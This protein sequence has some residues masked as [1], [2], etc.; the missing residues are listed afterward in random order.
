MRNGKSLREYL[1]AETGLKAVKPDGVPSL[2]AIAQ[3]DTLE[4]F[5]LITA[6]KEVG[7]PSGRSILGLIHNYYNANPFAGKTI[8]GILDEQGNNTQKIIG[9]GRFTEWTYATVFQ[10]KIRI[11]RNPIKKYTEE[12]PRELSFAT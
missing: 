11:T 2:E 5:E 10:D 8:L 12:S 7:L 3:R 6:S 9:E 4:Y 1:E